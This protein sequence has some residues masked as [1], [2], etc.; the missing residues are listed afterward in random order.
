M[1]ASF[2]AEQMF[3]TDQAFQMDFLTKEKHETFNRT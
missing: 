2:C 1:R 3:D